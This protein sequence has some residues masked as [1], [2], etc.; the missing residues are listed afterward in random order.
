MFLNQHI[1]Q[2]EEKNALGR[3][4]RPGKREKPFFFP[5]RNATFD[6]YDSNS[7]YPDTLGSF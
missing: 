7:H 5:A 2:K 4:K 6:I 1:S 3:K